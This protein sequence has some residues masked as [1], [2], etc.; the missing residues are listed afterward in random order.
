MPGWREIA[1]RAVSG[2]GVRAGELVQIREH[3]GRAEILLE[4]ALAVER[5]RATPLPELTPPAYVRR[6]L[7]EAGTDYLAAWD[8]HRIDWLRRVDRVLV[9]QGADL[10]LD[11]V[12][13]SARDAWSGAVQR[14]IEVEDERRL[15]FLLRPDPR[16]GG[17]AATAPGGVGSAAPGRPGGA[18]R[19]VATAD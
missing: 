14:L 10:P 12:P 9:L 4:T 19:G 2:L 3:S 8:R 11:A 18:G 5:A 17:C 13:D 6:L 15:P 7:T 16:A 1:D